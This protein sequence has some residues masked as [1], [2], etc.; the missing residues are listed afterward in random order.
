M[1]PYLAYFQSAE[2]EFFGLIIKSQ[3]APDGKFFVHYLDDNEQMH[4]TTLSEYKIT[5]INEAN[6]AHFRERHS[7]FINSHLR[8]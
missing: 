8:S 2:N 6:E 7:K 4:E 5:A 3:V 1:K